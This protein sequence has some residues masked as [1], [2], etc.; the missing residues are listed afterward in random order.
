MSSP[1]VA[2]PT[3]A[4]ATAELWTRLH[5]PFSPAGAV[6][7]MTGL[8]PMTSRQLVGIALATSA[9]ADHLLSHMNEIVRS[10]A[11]ATTT[12]P[13]RS[14]GEV[15]GPIMWSETLAARSASPGAGEVFI[16]AAPQKAYDTEENRVLVHALLKIRDAARDAD[17]SGQQSWEPDD[18]VRLARHNGSRAIRSLEHRTLASVAKTRPT[19]RGMSKAR[20]GAKARSYKAAVAVLERASEPISPQIVVDHSDDHTRRQHGLLLALQDRFVAA[21]LAPMEIR[22]ESGTLRAGPLRYLHRHRADSDGLYGVLLG[23]LLVDVPGAEGVS[24]P[25]AAE[26]ALGARSFGHPSLMV[27][28]PSDVDRAFELAGIR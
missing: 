26:A 7:A 10:L 24:D 15:R 9:E 28:R 23:N 6:E 1:E 3:A 2:L 11:I 5:R 12:K 19:G 20:S 17:V 22:V 21:H 16:C 14:V 27:L 4:A 18:A 13:I 8:S 25:L